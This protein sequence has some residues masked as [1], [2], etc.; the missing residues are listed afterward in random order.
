VFC[1]KGRGLGRSP[2]T[3]GGRRGRRT[4]IRPPAIVL[5][6]ILWCVSVASNG[7]RSSYLAN[8]DVELNSAHRSC[9]HFEPSAN[10]QE[11]VCDETTST[12]SLLCINQTPRYTKQ[13]RMQT[14][15]PESV[16]IATDASILDFEDRLDELWE[17]YLTL[18]DAYTK[19]QDEIKKHLILGFLS[20]ARAQSSAPLGRRYGQDWYDER[21]KAQRT[22]HV[23]S[24]PC[25]TRDVSISTGLQ[26]LSISLTETS[27]KTELKDTTDEPAVE[28][29][30][31]Q[32]T[33][34]PSPPGTPEPEA[35]EQS[36]QDEKG[37]EEEKPKPVNPLRWYG[38][39]VPPELKR[40]QSAFSAVLGDRSNA[41]EQDDKTCNNENS[42]TS[43]AV[44]AARG[45]REVE[46]EIRKLRKAVRK[47]EK[48][49]STIT[50]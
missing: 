34:Q 22:V 38:I 9:L 14:P 10:I 24:D 46:G 13:I 32:P 5:E 2:W 36:T 7:S 37:V 33:Q 31:S 30:K 21:M 17:S 23:S 15:E 20:L 41:E 49:R 8:D 47:A 4:G 18:L 16:H 27:T 45:L 25:K 50:H 43:N 3:L 6:N 28:G 44:N 26:R 19:A 39:L 48:A 40:A 42:P 1:V 29:E 11:H 12:T 35:R